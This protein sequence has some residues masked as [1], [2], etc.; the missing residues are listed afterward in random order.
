MWTGCP[1]DP[2]TARPV[3]AGQSGNHLLCRAQHSCSLAHT[4]AHSLT[5]YLSFHRRAGGFLRSA[6]VCKEIDNAKGKIARKLSII[7]SQSF[8]SWERYCS[9]LKLEARFN[10]L[11]LKTYFQ[12]QTRRYTEEVIGAWGFVYF[13]KGLDQ[14]K[15]LQSHNTLGVH[16]T[17]FS[18]KKLFFSCGRGEIIWC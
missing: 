17:I 3:Q 4:A 11:V 1:T 7:V 15:D 10:L 18:E 8:Y 13:N 2:L 9:E 16:S 14:G 5:T 12:G 6:L